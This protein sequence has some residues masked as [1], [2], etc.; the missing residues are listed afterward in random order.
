MKVFPG[1]H[2]CINTVQYVIMVGEKSASSLENQK[3]NY[4]ISPGPLNQI[5]GNL[6]ATFQIYFFI[7]R[8][9]GNKMESDK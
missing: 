9:M 4:N 8:V 1:T 5:L 2:Y 7:K 6:L 3:Q